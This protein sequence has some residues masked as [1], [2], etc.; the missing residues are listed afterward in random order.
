VASEWDIE[1]KFRG[2]VEHS[3]RLS[4]ARAARRP[5]PL[6]CSLHGGYRAAPSAAATPLLGALREG[7]LLSR[8]CSGVRTGALQ[9]RCTWAHFQNL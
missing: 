7:M 8:P 1:E 4:I 6:P 3:L 9:I 5:L 2:T